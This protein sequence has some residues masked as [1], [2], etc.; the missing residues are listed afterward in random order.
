MNDPQT[1]IAP[2]SR[3]NNGFFKPQI[4]LSRNS[5][6]TFCL[7]MARFFRIGGRRQNFLLPTDMADWLS[8]DDTVHLIIDA[9]SLLDLS[10]FEVQHRG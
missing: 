4:P 3:K 8:T 1:S 5:D 9:V 6:H 7:P 10:G 2:F